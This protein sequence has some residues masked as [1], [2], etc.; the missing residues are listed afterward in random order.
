MI[1]FVA[2][3]LLYAIPVIAGVAL[4]TFLIA[5]LLPGDLAALMLGPE[6]TQERLAEVRAELGLDRPPWVRFVEWLGDAVRGDLGRSMRTGQSVAEAI[7]ERLPVTV[8]LMLLAQAG[9]LALA[10]PVA[11]ACAVR[12]GGRLDRAL[13][14]AAFASL[15]VPTVMSAILLIWLFAVRLEWLPATGYVPLQEGIADNL[16]GFVLPAATLALAEWPVL[17]RVLRADLVA[18]LR[19]DFVTM[20]RA[21]GLRDARI[22]WVHA[23]K[24]SSLTLVTVTGL[25]VGRLLGGTV[26][27]EQ[28]FALP[29]LGRLLVGSI[30]GRDLVVLQGTV[31][32]VAVA[33]VLVNTAVDVAYAALDPRVRRGRG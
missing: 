1:R 15:S 16:A 27:V 10:L 8:E 6:E 29:G 9:A 21:K 2:L 28:I 12:P 24:P 30:Y 3:R 5:A 25:N 18:T 19:E 26:I 7:G 4:L 11:I 13:S 20:A 32:F 14:G 33:F 22:L 17:M 23:L 31:L